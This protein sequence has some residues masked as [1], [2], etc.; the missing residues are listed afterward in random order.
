MITLSKENYEKILEHAQKNLPEEACGLIAG[1]IDG[2]KKHIEKVYLL[3]YN[4][5]TMEFRKIKLPTNTKDCAVCGDH[6][7]IDHLIDYEQAVC[8]MKH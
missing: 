4:A 7:T 3:T 1:R 6:P 2:E 5:L 8:E